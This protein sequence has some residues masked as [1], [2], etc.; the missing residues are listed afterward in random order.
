MTAF[1]PATSGDVVVNYSHA[2]N[3]K[4]AILRFKGPTSYDAAGSTIDLSSAVASLAAFSGF[5]K[6]YGVQLIAQSTAANDKYYL[7]YVPADETYLAATG[8]I[9]VRD[10]TAAADAEVT[11]ATDLSAVIFRL[12]VWGK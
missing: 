6:V 7:T 12:I 2:V 4:K 8:K 5:S 9:K 1:L 10:L 11:A 3:Q